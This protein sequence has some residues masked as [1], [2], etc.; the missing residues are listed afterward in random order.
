MIIATSPTSDNFKSSRVIARHATSNGRS[1]LY[2][3]RM[4]KSLGGHSFCNCSLQCSLTQKGGSCR[5][6]LQVKKHL[7]I[8]SA[9]PISLAHSPRIPQTFL[10]VKSQCS[11][12]VWPCCTT[13]LLSLLAA[14]NEKYSFGVHQSSFLDI[15]KFLNSTYSSLCQFPLCLFLSSVLFF[16][17]PPSAKVT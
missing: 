7:F 11:D 1:C 15:K 5:L 10:H 6:S 9:F 17:L 13:P 14:N 16:D 3:L 12:Q 8:P 2:L 4:Q